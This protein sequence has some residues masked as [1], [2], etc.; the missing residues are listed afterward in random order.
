LVGRWLRGRDIMRSLLRR[1]HPGRDDPGDRR[2][3]R[4]VKELAEGNKR[5]KGDERFVGIA[6]SEAHGGVEHPLG[7]GAEGAIR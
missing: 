2:Q 7:Q 6:E 3:R 5:I 1:A 4:R